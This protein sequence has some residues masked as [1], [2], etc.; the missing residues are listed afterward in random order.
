[1][2]HNNVNVNTVEHARYIA[3]ELLEETSALIEQEEKENGVETERYKRLKKKQE[4]VKFIEELLLNELR[5]I[6]Y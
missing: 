5:A 4:S 6:F 3:L 1:M 2:A